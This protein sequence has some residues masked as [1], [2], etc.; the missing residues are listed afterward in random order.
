MHAP[1]CA[2]MSAR[3]CMCRCGFVCAHV[4]VVCMYAYA[5]LCVHVHVCVLFVCACVRFMCVVCLSMCMC[6]QVCFHVHMHTCACMFTH[7]CV[8]VLRVYACVHVCACARMCLCA[9]IVCLCMFACV[10]VCVCV[11]IRVERGVRSSGSAHLAHERWKGIK[12]LFVS[13]VSPGPTMSRPGPELGAEQPK[14]LAQGGRSPVWGGQADGAGHTS[15]GQ[16]CGLRTVRRGHTRPLAC[17]WASAS[18]TVV[19]ALKDGWA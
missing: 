19:R 18:W 15:A 8:R 11:C 9:C 3:T 5:C 17:P 13:K 6:A 10:H 12:S 7:V 2:H 4:R 16:P 1:A 14:A